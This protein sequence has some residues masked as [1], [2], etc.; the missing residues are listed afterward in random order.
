MRNKRLIAVRRRLLDS[1]ENWVTWPFEQTCCWW[2]IF[3]N[4]EFDNKL[5]LTFQQC[6]IWLKFKLKNIEVIMVYKGD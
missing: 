2:S 6:R 3:Q 4:A 5:T 1:G